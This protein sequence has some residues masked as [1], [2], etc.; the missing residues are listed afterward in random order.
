MRLVLSFCLLLMIPV[1]NAR[2]RIGIN[3]LGYLPN[4][5]KAGLLFSTDPFDIQEFSLLYYLAAVGINH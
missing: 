3:Q 5:V 4:S 2:S 1:L